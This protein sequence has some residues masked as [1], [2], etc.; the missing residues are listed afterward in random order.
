MSMICLGFRKSKCPWLHWS[1]SQLYLLQIPGSP[2]PSC[3][4]TFTCAASL[5]SH[6]SPGHREPGKCATEQFKYS[7]LL[8]PC[9]VS[10]PVSQTPIDDLFTS[11]WFLF[12]LE[13][14]GRNHRRET[15]GH[16]A[17]N[18]RMH[19]FMGTVPSRGPAHA[20]KPWASH[21]PSLSP[22]AYL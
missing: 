8:S 18:Q 14:G 7:W 4:S 19:N 21:L 13:Q 1:S 16:G 2:H 15:G 6:V 11:G 17:R 5:L 3:P 22:P 10:C 12:G 20:K 9:K